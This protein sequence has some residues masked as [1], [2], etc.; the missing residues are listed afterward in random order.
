MA[1]CAQRMGHHSKCNGSMDIVR[2]DIEYYR[3]QRRMY[4]EFPWQKI[5][6]INNAMSMLVKRMNKIMA[7]TAFY[8]ITK[9]SYIFFYY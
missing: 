6:Y 7:I 8:S 9:S 5:V 4:I 3:S 2:Y 1:L